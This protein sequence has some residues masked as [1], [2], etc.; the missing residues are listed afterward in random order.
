MATGV[1]RWAPARGSPSGTCRRRE[2]GRLHLSDP[3]SPV[4]QLVRRR[5]RLPLARPSPGSRRA[6]GGGRDLRGRRSRS[7]PF[8]AGMHTEGEYG[9]HARDWRL[10]GLKHRVQRGPVPPPV[11]VP[12][13]LPVFPSPAGTVSSGNS[14]MSEM[15]G[16]RRSSSKARP[17]SGCRAI[18]RATWANVR[19][20]QPTPSRCLSCSSTWSASMSAVQ[21]RPGCDWGSRLSRRELILTGRDPP[22]RGDW[23]SSGL[24]A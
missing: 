8:R 16:E 9:R 6:G 5:C 15:Y 20:W 22:T 24:S 1:R 17:G 18:Q 23:P 4:A 3:E 10:I 2:S 14:V 12:V 19:Q 7:S 13:V 11:M 21:Q